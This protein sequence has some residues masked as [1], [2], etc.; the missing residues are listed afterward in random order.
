MGSLFSIIETGL[1]RRESGLRKRRR[2]DLSHV[3][4]AEA[5]VAAV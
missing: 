1:R 4:I 3:L 5:A 2:N